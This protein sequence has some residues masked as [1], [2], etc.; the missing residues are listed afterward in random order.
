MYSAEILDEFAREMLG[1]ARRHILDRVTD[2]PISSLSLAEA[3]E[4]QDRV[5]AAR[6]R[7]GERAVGWKIGC[8]S[9][10]I[11]SQFGLS[12]PVCARLMAPHVYSSGAVLKIDDYLGP[13]VEPE[14]VLHITSTI[15]PLSVSDEDLYAAIGGVSAGI[16]LH[17]YTF[18][19]GDPTSQELIAS[20]ALHAGQVVSDL[21]STNRRDLAIEGVGVWVNHEL[22]VSAMGA[23]ILGSGPLKSLRWLVG[24]LA[25]RG[26]RVAAGDIVIPG[27]PVRL[28]RV[29]EGDVVDARFTS[30][31]V[32][33]ATF[34]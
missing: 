11:Q 13:A 25:G 34:I 32:C 20:N 5:I 7:D 27:S 26:S 16:E 9:R 19:Y 10:A 4:V 18:A 8:T 12:E 21:V 23:E 3:Y 28:V 31:G 2:I 29:V 24:Q 15:D 33:R 30:L 17:N 14:F 22:V 6:E 1:V